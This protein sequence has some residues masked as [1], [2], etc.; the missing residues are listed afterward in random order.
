MSNNKIG[1]YILYAIGEIVLVV[2]GI[3]I[4]VQIDDWNENRK[5]KELENK[6]LTELI[7]DLQAQAKDIKGNIK[8]HRTGEMSCYAIIRTI[9][10]DIPLH[11]SLKRHFVKTYDF[12]VFKNKDG[13]YKMLESQGISLIGNDSLRYLITDYFEWSVPFILEVQK[14]TMQQIVNASEK[15][16]KLFRNFQWGE[17]LEPWDYEALKN[18]Q[19]YVSWLNYTAKN[20]KFEAVS[21]QNL[22]IRNNKLIKAIDSELSKTK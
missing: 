9:Q 15:H 22:L 3:L 4:A 11:D 7:S 6:L 21:Y 18:N 12:T 13:A 16:L 19:E 2:L 8:T 1:T 17:P 20:K 10:E 5:L 14:V